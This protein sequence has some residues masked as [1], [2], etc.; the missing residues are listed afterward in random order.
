MEVSFI[1]FY[2][3]QRKT[4]SLGFLPAIDHLPSDEVASVIHLMIYSRGS[5]HLL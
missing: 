4:V 2:N 5:P 3:T 1:I